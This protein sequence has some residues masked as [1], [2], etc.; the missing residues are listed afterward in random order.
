MYGLSCKSLFEGT[1]GQIPRRSPSSV[2]V[3]HDPTNKLAFPPP[4]HSIF[5]FRVSPQTH[6]LVLFSAG[7]YQ[8]GHFLMGTL[9]LLS[10]AFVP[11]SPEDAA[12]MLKTNE[13]THSREHQMDIFVEEIL[14]SSELTEL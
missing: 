6:L 9:K 11:L 8:V 7:T 10:V 5:P 1:Y 3:I 14:F 4:W 12:M 2:L 13:K